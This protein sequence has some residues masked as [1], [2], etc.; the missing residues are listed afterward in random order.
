MKKIMGKGIAVY[1]CFLIM[2]LTPAAGIFSKAEAGVKTLAGGALIGGGVVAGAAALSGAAGAGAAAGAA[3]TS[4]LGAIGGAIGAMFAGVAGVI[5]GIGSIIG[6]ALSTIGL[7]VG[8]AFLL[9]AKLI[10]NPVVLAA[11]AVIGGALLIKHM[12]DKRNC[13]YA[14]RYDRRYGRRYQRGDDIATY[15]YRDQRYRDEIYGNQYY[16]RDPRNWFERTWDGV[17]EFF[18]GDKY[19]HGQP[20]YGQRA[21]TGGGYYGDN[22]FQ[23][24]FFNNGMGLGPINYTQPQPNPQHVPGGMVTPQNTQ[25]QYNQNLLTGAQSPSAPGEEE[26]EAETIRVKIEKAVESRDKAYTELVETLRANPVGVIEGEARPEDDPRKEA[27]NEYKKWDKVV[28]DLK[29][30]LQSKEKQ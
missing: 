26:M 12:M 20:Y 4:F 6:G 18:T 1:L 9:S 23:D 16:P 27:L 7:V 21:Y 8:G 2:F 11:V 28:N 25:A 29:E 15:G 22:V 13:D 19:Y 5:G 17:K 10:T 14:Y 24:P 30:M 3:G